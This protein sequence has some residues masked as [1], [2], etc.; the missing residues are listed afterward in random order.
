MLAKCNSSPKRRRAPI[1]NV[2]R[3]ICLLLLGLLAVLMGSSWLGL[4]GQ[5]VIASLA[6]SGSVAQPAASSPEPPPESREP[7]PLVSAMA[8]PPVLVEVRRGGSPP[9][10]RVEVSLSEQRVRVYRD[11]E[12][13]REMI[14]STGA[15]D[16]PT[17]TGRFRIEN[18]GEWF[19]S[20]KY[21]QGAKWWV[22]FYGRGKYLFHSVPMDARQQIIA[23]EADKLGQP[24]SHGCVRLS[25]EDA[26]WFYQT[27][28]EGTPVDIYD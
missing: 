15:P 14:A 11:G 4:T 3:T 2:R 19:Y 6:E 8:S 25:L 27:V 13:L 1:L 21:Q 17:P 22:S 7:Q 10:Y 23:A 18:R 20:P 28:P 9:S 12:L 24:A 26:F 16:T 5:P